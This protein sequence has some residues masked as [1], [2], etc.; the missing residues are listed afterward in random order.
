MIA[1][2]S[3]ATFHRQFKA[4]TGMS[5]LH[6]QKELR[7]LEARRL[8]LSNGSNVETAATDSR[9]RKCIAVQPRVCADV[10]PAATP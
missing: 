10:W 4:T 6:Y 1:H 3:S 2:M 8:M 9:L 7:L 5:P